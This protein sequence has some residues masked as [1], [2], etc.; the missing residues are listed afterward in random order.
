[1]AVPKGNPI[2]DITEMIMP[3]K[4][5]MVVPNDELGGST[6]N[7]NISG[8]NISGDE[9]SLDMMAEKITAELTRILQLQQLNSV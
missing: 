6:I 5:G 4:G 1:M 2:N 7:V 8:N 3:N 9:S